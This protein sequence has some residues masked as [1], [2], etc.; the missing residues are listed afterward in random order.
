MR[1]RIKFTKTGVMKFIG[2]LDT[3]RYFQKAVRRA[4]LPVEYSEGYSPHMLMSFAAPLSVGVTSSAEYFDID[5]RT[6]GD[7]KSGPAKNRPSPGAHEVPRIGLPGEK[8][9]S[10]EIVRRLNEQM[11]EGVT[12]LSA[13]RI[14]EKKAEKGMS[15]VS[16]ADYSVRIRDGKA[17]GLPVTE[18]AVADFLRRGVISAVKKGKAGE[19]EVNIRPLIYD[20]HL[21]KNFPDPSGAGLEDG[22]AFRM[23]ISQGSRDNLKP[24]LLMGA[25]AE[26]YGMTFGREDLMIHRFEI[27]ADTAPQ[28]SGGRHLVPLEALGEQIE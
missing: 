13:V 25:Y 8:L 27:F 15:V 14:G 12:V 20:L 18:E 23:L 2:H 17:V 28:G 19:R 11:V 3:M 6:P 1:V 26:T 24:E 21:E 5:L 16:A 9:T 7:E 22:T 10:K 4:H